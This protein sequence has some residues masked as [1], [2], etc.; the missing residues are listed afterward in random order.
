MIALLAVTVFS[1][2]VWSEQS[3]RPFGDAIDQAAGQ[4]MGDVSFHYRS[5]INYVSV[6]G[7]LLLLVGLL[8]L[9]RHFWRAG[10]KKNAA[11]LA[12]A[13]ALT[14]VAGWFFVTGAAR[15]ASYRITV[16]KSRLKVDVPFGQHLNLGW[17]EITGVSAK[18]E[19]VTHTYRKVHSDS[20]KRWNTLEI[21]TRRGKTHTLDLSDLGLV[22]RS[23][24]IN[25]IM[26]RSGM[27][28]VE[29]DPPPL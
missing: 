7:R 6:L 2:C 4:P 18:G 19:R 17:T 28:K 22:Q 3:G 23:N 21:I 24:L 9:V 11:A 27:R 26:E 15:V 25:A 13:V 8:G 12:V 5:T 10:I 20:Y 1:G 29:T 14:G 16:S